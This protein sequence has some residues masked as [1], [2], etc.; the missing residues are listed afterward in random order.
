M[1]Q[2]RVNLSQRLRALVLLVAAVL[3]SACSGVN[4]DAARQLSLGGRGA[5]G[6]AKQT[7]I[8]SN[9]EYGRA[10]DAEAEALAKRKEKRLNSADGEPERVVLRGNLDIFD[11]KTDATAKALQENK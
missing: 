4:L 2:H 11:A 10:R 9:E 1:Q 7:A 3:G 8:A 5:A 6:E